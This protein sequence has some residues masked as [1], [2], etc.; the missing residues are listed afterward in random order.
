MADKEQE[1]RQQGEKG[2]RHEGA[3]ITGRTDGPYKS[4]GT[5]ADHAAQD[6]KNRPE[7]EDSANGLDSL[8]IRGGQ[9]GRNNRGIG[10]TDMDSQNGL[11]RLGDQDDDLPEDVTQ[12]GLSQ[13]GKSNT[14][15]V[16]V[17]THG[18]D[19]YASNDEVP[20]PKAQEKAKEQGDSTDANDSDTNSDQS[21]EEKE[22]EVGQTGTST[23]HQPAY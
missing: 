11:L 21:Q 13:A 8:Q 1:L 19:D 3:Q 20:T 22:E 16:S 15:M 14:S 7:Q 18:P 10:S 5:D 4:D 17:T 6:N 9:D 23:S 12:E 2:V